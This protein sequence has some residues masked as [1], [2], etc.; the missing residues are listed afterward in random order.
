LK[1]ILVI[2][3]I[4]SIFCQGGKNPWAVFNVSSNANDFYLSNSNIS[5]GTKG[6]YQFANPA[7]LPK[8]KNVNYAMTYNM[9]SLDR[10]CQILSVN[11]P[12]PP[13]AGVAISMI[14][15][16]TS[17][18]QGRDSF[19]NNNNM[20][21]NYDMLGMISFGVSFSKYIF[22]GLNIKASYSNLD[23]MF[24]DNN[25]ANYSISSRGIGLDG[26]FLINYSD[27]S[28]GLKVENLKSSKNWDL[29]LDKG[30]SYSEQVPII[31]K[32][33][34]HYKILDFLSIYCA[35]N[36]ILNDYLLNQFGVEFFTNNIG[37]GFGISIADESIS[38]ALGFY[39]SGQLLELTSF[40]FSYGINS[41][42]VDEG[43]SHIFTWTFGD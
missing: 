33:G 27:L 11:V 3:F 9:M 12:L 8:I 35:Y 14:R 34:S 40:E 20:F 32:V 43:I 30:N 5:N 28:L 29:N 13:Q 39:Y 6:F 24:G 2:L 42:R 31:Y 37:F 7:L 17:K 19:N 1:N 4:S 36:N 38:P 41:G 15:S 18:I 16:G 25:E 21:Q 10:S 26:G 23:N 22:G